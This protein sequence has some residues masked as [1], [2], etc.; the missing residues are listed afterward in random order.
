MS[1]DI[2]KSAIAAV[3]ALSLV[4]AAALPAHALGKKDKAFIAGAATAAAAGAVIHNMQ[5]RNAPQPAP[6]YY[7]EPRATYA[8]PVYS[9]PRQVAPAARL[10]PAAQA[11]REMSPQ[12]RRDVQVSLARQGYY[13]GQI[14][15]AWGPG[16]ARAV[17]AYARDSGRA[18]QMGTTAG[19][20]DVLARLAG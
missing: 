10:A 3:A 16:T 2:R 1:F 17:D 11:F 18:G 7:T 12:M 14:D 9:Q 5:T 4:P 19:A 8:T 20:Y 6:R 15:G 13:R